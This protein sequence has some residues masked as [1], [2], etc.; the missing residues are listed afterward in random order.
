MGQDEDTKVRGM[1]L[2][3]VIGYNFCHW[4]EKFVSVRKTKVQLHVFPALLLSTQPLHLPSHSFHGGSFHYTPHPL[5][6]SSPVT[7][8]ALYAVVPKDPVPSQLLASFLDKS[9]N[10][11]SNKGNVTKRKRA[12]GG[13]EGDR[14]ER[15]SG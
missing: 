5:P 2:R 10:K 11:K 13:W 9:E 14:E 7:F 15:E 1:N 3:Y 6:L 8:R 4:H 12:E